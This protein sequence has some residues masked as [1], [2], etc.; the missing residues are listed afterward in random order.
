MGTRKTAAPSPPHRDRAATVVAV[1]TLKN[2]VIATIPVGQQPQQL[3]Y[4]PR[5]AFPEVLGTS[6]SCRS[7]SPVKQ[8]ISP[9]RRPRAVASALTSPSR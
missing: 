9:C 1:D 6:T 8:A 4:V 7:A 2:K 3:L 5:A